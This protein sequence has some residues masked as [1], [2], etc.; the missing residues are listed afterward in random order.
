MFSRF[1]RYAFPLLLLAY[2]GSVGALMGCADDDVYH[3]LQDPPQCNDE[4]DCDDSDPCTGDQC[5]AGQCMWSSNSGAQCSPRYATGPGICVYGVCRSSCS[6]AAQCMARPCS[7]AE[8]IGGVCAY[9]PFS[10]GAQ[11][12]SDGIAGRCDG[13]GICVVSTP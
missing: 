1:S 9:V 2:A 3:V 4:T 8:C 6:D 13:A 10:D 7:S 11:C 5:V 12:V